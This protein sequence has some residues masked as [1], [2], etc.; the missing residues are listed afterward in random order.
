MALNQIIYSMQQTDDKGVFCTD[1][2]QEYE[3]AASMFGLT[4]EDVW[5]LSQQ[6]IDCTFAPETL[7]QQLKQ[8]WIDL[9]PRVF[10]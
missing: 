2:S 1:L 9:R 7:K 4:H 10:R 8:R 3:L 6:A 5:K